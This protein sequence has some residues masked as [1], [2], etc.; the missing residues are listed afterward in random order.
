MWM[1]KRLGWWAF[2]V[3]AF[4]GIAVFF[5]AMGA[6]WRRE[7]RPALFFGFLLLVAIGWIYRLMARI[8]K[9]DETPPEL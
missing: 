7:I 9:P 8:W 1:V 5:N 3:C 6:E 2:M 4:L